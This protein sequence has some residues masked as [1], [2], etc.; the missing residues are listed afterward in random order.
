MCTIFQALLKAQ[1]AEVKER[2]TSKL[3]LRRLWYLLLDHEV[4]EKKHVY[5]YMLAG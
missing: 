5:V 4:L 1:G 3:M 2:P